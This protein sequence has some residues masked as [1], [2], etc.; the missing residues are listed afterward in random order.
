MC[1]IWPEPTGARTRVV[2]SELSMF[3]WSHPVPQ[4]KALQV[5][6]TG[7]QGRFWTFTL[8]DGVCLFLCRR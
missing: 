8:Y 6:L 1:E 4:E 7:A 5:L 3:C 2:A